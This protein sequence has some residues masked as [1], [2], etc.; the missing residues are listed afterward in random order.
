MNGDKKK[1]RNLRILVG[2][3][4]AFIVV[5]FIGS[6]EIYE[7]NLSLQQDLNCTK[8]QVI[9]YKSVAIDAQ[10]KMEDYKTANEQLIKYSTPCSVTKAVKHTPL[11]P[12]KRG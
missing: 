1:I 11:P 4:I 9:I 7:Y 8:Q 10:N 5:D 6:Y 3:L 2:L 12:L